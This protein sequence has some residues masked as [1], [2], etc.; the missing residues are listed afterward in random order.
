MAATDRTT[1]QRHRVLQILVRASKRAL[2]L[3]DHYFLL[4]DDEFEYHPGMYGRGNV[5]PGGTTEGAHVVE[6]RDICRMCYEKLMIDFSLLEDRRL[7]STYYPFLNCETLVTGIS[8]QSLH[9]LA[10]PFVVGLLCR[11]KW[12]YAVALLLAAVVSLLAYSKYVFSRTRRT[13]C[14]HL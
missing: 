12:L 8:V 7:M 1:R 11:G 2:G 9:A 13:R 10:L 4:V 5:L 3:V 14:Q 6:R